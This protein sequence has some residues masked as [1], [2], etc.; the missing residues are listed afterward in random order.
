MAPTKPANT[1]ADRE[2]AGSTTPV[3]IVA[4]TFVPKHEEGDE[5]E[6]R[7]PEDGHAGA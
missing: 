4:A 5:V 7:G 2:D 3:A 1:T 6:R